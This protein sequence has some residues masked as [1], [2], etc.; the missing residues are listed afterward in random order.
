VDIIL[1]SDDNERVYAFQKVAS[2]R[3]R[4]TCLKI[5]WSILTPLIGP[6]HQEASKGLDIN[7]SIPLSSGNLKKLYLDNASNGVND[8]VVSETDMHVTNCSGNVIICALLVDIV[9]KYLQSVYPCHRKMCEID[10]YYCL[11]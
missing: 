7:I 5:N 9:V 6:E 1:T 2:R 3:A 8:S 10:A 4:K 11:C